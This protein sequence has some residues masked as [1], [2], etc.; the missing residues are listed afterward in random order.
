[1][2]FNLTAAAVAS[3]NSDNGMHQYLNGSTVTC[4][5]SAEFRGLV[6]K[7]NPHDLSC[8]YKRMFEMCATN[9]LR[10]LGVN[11]WLYKMATDF[12]VPERICASP[13][14][15]EKRHVASR[16]SLMQSNLVGVPIFY[17]AE[18]NKETKHIQ[19]W[20]TCQQTHSSSS[21]PEHRPMVANL[22]KKEK[23]RS[24]SAL[25]KL[26][27]GG[28]DERPRPVRANSVQC[29]KAMSS[30]VISNKQE[31]PQ[32]LNT[33]T[34]TLGTTPQISYRFRHHDDLDCYMEQYRD[35]YTYKRLAL[36]RPNMNEMRPYQIT[37][38]VPPLLRCFD[39]FGCIQPP[40]GCGPRMSVSRLSAAGST[41]TGRTTPKMQ[42][43]KKLIK[44]S[45]G[46]KSPESRPERQTSNVLA[47][48][49]GILKMEFQGQPLPHV[50]PPTT[51]TLTS[52]RK[53]STSVY[54]DP[55]LSSVSVNNI[56]IPIVCRTRPTIPSNA[57]GT[58][59][60]SSTETPTYVVSYHKNK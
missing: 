51:Q 38:P 28:K 23:H 34:F 13:V 50:Q 43:K 6:Y 18:A 1:M 10:D 25:G 16:V 42:A 5:Y 3:S 22:S 58:I 11:E 36:I 21:L 54:S 33:H 26:E 40:P 53:S 24:Q 60:A 9:A 55:C 59:Y 48:E 35:Q 4:K 52:G 45:I 17:P 44:A 31:T 30:E 49:N 8:V 39:M 32:N 14:E 56:K 12:G 41:P 47:A 57:H 46:I 7:V 2:R 19:G 15:T 29:R 20:Q 27:C 37:L